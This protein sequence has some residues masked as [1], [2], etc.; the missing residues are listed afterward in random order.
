MLDPG[1]PGPGRGYIGARA[2][3]RAPPAPRTIVGERFRPLLRAEGVRRG[4][5]RHEL[6]SPQGRGA[7]RG[8]GLADCAGR[9]A[10]SGANVVSLPCAT[11]TGY[12]GFSKDPCSRAS[13]AGAMHEESCGGAERFRLLVEGVSVTS[14]ASCV[15]GGSYVASRD[16]GAERIAGYA[17]AAEIVGGHF[18]RFRTMQTRTAGPPPWEELATAN[19][20]PVASETEGWRVRKN[21]ERF[22]AR[23]GHPL[24]DGEQRLYGF[25]RS[26]RTWRAR[27]HIRSL[28]RAAKRGT[29]RVLARE[30][31]QSAGADRPAPS[32]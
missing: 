22:W 11:R 8:R 19:G 9:H 26:H 15:D 24:R 32:I 6:G 2:P 5:P 29:S 28:E 18:A 13:R 4:W 21:G 20:A 27:R 25:A 30:L 23:R 31:R 12:L 1:E 14:T 3:G 7:L 16:T 17:R 10:G